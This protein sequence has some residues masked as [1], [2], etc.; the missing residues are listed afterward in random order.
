MEIEIVDDLPPEAVA[1]LQSLYSRSPR[2]VREHLIEVNKRGPEKFMSQYYVGYGHKSI[3][4]GGTTT[5]FIEGVSMLVAKAVQDHSL[6][7]GQ[8]AS[9]RYMDMNATGVMNPLN[10][11]EGLLIQ[12]RWMALYTAVLNDLMREFRLAYPRLEDEKPSEWEKAI[13]AKAFDIARGFLPAGTRTFVSW[14]TNLRQAHDHLTWLDHHPLIE[15][16]V[17]AKAIREA[18]TARYPSSFGHSPDGA[19]DYRDAVMDQHTYSEGT[20]NPHRFEMDS[21]LFDLDAARELF[22][23]GPPRPRKTELHPRTRELGILRFY[24]GLDFGSFRDLQ[25]HRSAVISMPLLV[26]R[27]GFHPWYLD[28][29]TP[30]LRAMAEDTL[31][32]QEV[33]IASLPGGELTHQY[34]TAMGYMLPVKVA[35]PLPSAVYIAELRTGQTVHPTLRVQAQNMGNEVKGLLPDLELYHDTTPDQWSVKRGKQDIVK[36][37]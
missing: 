27:H 4:D 11:P 12:Q 33:A 10:S 9:T 32:R 5:I 35:G 23:Y 2:S 22:A 29:L 18:L 28:Q 8:E 3:G 25:R 13:K 7:N 34:Y 37:E 14:H 1:M 16:R 17:A 20:W 24:F 6:Y 21:S 19:G 26:R 30:S 15:V 36:K 31:N